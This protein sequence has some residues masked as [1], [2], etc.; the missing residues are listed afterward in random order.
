MSG[1][2]AI[3]TAGILFDMDGVLISSIGSVNRCWRRWAEHYGLPNAE[4]VQIEH[5]TRAVDMIAKLKPDLDVAEGLRFIE[6]MEIDDVAD[7]KVLPGARALLESLPPE[8]WAIVT[9]AT[10]RLLLGRLKAAELPVPERII[11]G[12][13]VECGKP[14]PEP[15]RRGAELI[16]SAASECLV[17]ED[18]PSGVGA[19]IAAGCRVLGVL[20][21]HSEA[22]LR[23]AGASWIVRSLEDVSAKV[24]PRG[25][26]LNLETV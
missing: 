10:Y 15:Y 6:D 26:V 21:T 11:S 13:M 24:S 22:E 1:S 23:A 2:V 14:D 12:D 5:G 17:V 16:Q 8:R 25:L 3:E 9:S 18:A 19:G 20:G 4:S 7:L